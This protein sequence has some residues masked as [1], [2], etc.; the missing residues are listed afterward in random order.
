MV[1]VSSSVH[2]FY[3]SPE[4]M[5]DLGVLPPSFPSVGATVLPLQGPGSMKD[6]HPPKDQHAVNAGCSLSLV[7]SSVP[8]SCPACTVVTDRPF[9]LPF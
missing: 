4:A 9:V 6:Q 1:Y 3:L 7:V 2:G 8:C 5:L